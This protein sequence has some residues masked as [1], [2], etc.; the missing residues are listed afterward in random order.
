MWLTAKCSTSALS[1]EI[2][3]Y[4]GLTLNLT[5]PL[6]CILMLLPLTEINKCTMQQHEEM[7]SLSEIYGRC[8]EIL[9]ASSSDLIKLHFN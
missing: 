5:S 8:G 1:I 9:N 7:F 2:Y 6:L 4:T 3:C